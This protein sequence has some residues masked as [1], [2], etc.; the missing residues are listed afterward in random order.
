M[1]CAATALLKGAISANALFKLYWLKS[2]KQFL[3][4]FRV[5]LLTSLG[6][7]MVGHA[8]QCWHTKNIRCHSAISHAAAWNGCLKNVQ[9]FLGGVDWNT[10][11]ILVTS[12]HKSSGVDL[13][14][15][16]FTPPQT[17]WIL[18]PLMTDHLSPWPNHNFGLH[19]APNSPSTNAMLRPHAL[20]H[21]RHGSWIG[22]ETEAAAQWIRRTSFKTYPIHVWRVHFFKGSWRLSAEICFVHSEKTGVG[23][24]ISILVSVSMVI[25]GLNTLLLGSLWIKWLSFEPGKALWCAPANHGRQVLQ[26][27]NSSKE[28]ASTWG[29][30]GAWGSVLVSELIFKKC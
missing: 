26:T 18:E 14:E 27:G 29:T 28:D 10:W 9:W 3:N 30:Q 5:N 16:V 22:L 11:L 15:M 12:Y 2:P 17:S 6:I 1:F 8:M 13:A 25:G 20:W 7:G 4:Y 19:G 21:Q 23:F 24:A